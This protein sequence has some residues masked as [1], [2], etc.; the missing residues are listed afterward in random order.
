M[1]PPFPAGRGECPILA[2]IPLGLQAVPDPVAKLP[3]ARKLSIVCFRFN[4]SFL[5]TSVCI[6]NSVNLF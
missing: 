1:G 2:I 4:C 3:A 6:L 5:F